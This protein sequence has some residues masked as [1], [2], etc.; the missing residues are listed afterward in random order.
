MRRIFHHRVHTVLYSSTSADKS[1]RKERPM[2]KALLLICAASILAGNVRLLQNDRKSRLAFTPD[3]QYHIINDPGSPDSDTADHRSN[4]CGNI[5]ANYKS[6]NNDRKA[7]NLEHVNYRQVRNE[8]T[9]PC[10]CSVY[11]RWKS[12]PSIK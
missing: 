5:N 1:G 2:K 8:K 11:P 3:S 9:V 10:P 4:Y 6:G 12:R 7:R